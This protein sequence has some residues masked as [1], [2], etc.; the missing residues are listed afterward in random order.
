MVVTMQRMANMMDA[1]HIDE[2]PV[3]ALGNLAEIT[4]ILDKKRVTDPDKPKPQK[5]RKLAFLELAQVVF[6][7]VVLHAR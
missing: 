2:S 4:L 3:L 7:N 5:Y 6:T 1:E